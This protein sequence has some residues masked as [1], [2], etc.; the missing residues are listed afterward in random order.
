[1]SKRSKQRAA[2]AALD[3]IYARL[4]PIACQG[5]CH[6]ACGPILLT[7]LE[8]QRLKT[9][10][11]A[12]PRTVGAESHERCAYLSAAGRCQVY[13][14]RP[15]IC[16]AWG[17]IRMLSCMR[18]CVPAAWVSETVFAELAQA[19]ERIGGPL[20]RTGPDGL[21]RDPDDTFTHWSVRTRSEA[22]IEATAE[23]TRSLR[24]LHGGRI[25][26]ALD[27]RDDENYG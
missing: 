20:L 7:T 4:P 25:M 27:R 14:V 10:T 11:H 24:A 15:F 2:W 5:R 1:M 13:T 17:V 21:S 6:T 22:A 16:R 26:V 12:T 19:L 23:R 8:A 18:G 9:I 3:A